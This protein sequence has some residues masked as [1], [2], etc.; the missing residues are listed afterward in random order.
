MPLLSA[1]NVVRLWNFGRRFFSSSRFSPQFRLNWDQHDV[2]GDLVAFDWGVLNLTAPRR[3]YHKRSMTASVML[4][5]GYEDA[6]VDGIQGLP[7]LLLQTRR[8]LLFWHWW[9]V[10]LPCQNDA[11]SHRP[12]RFIRF[13]NRVLPPQPVYHFHRRATLLFHQDSI[14]YSPDWTVEEI[15]HQHFLAYAVLNFWHIKVRD[16]PGWPIHL[17]WLCH[18]G[19]TTPTDAMDSLLDRMTLEFETRMKN[20]KRAGK[21]EKNHPGDWH[22][23]EL[24]E[25]RDELLLFLLTI[26]RVLLW[27]NRLGVW[28]A[29]SENYNLQMMHL[30]LDAFDSFPIADRRA[31]FDKFRANLFSSRR[32]S[33]RCPSGEQSGIT[34]L[35]TPIGPARLRLIP[36]EEDPRV[37]RD[38][39]TVFSSEEVAVSSG[40]LLQGVEHA[41][42]GYVIEGEELD[43]LLRDEGLEPG[44][45]L[46]APLPLPPT[47]SPSP[48]PRDLTPPPITVLEEDFVPLPPS[49]PPEE[50]PWFHQIPSHGSGN[51]TQRAPKSALARKPPPNHERTRR[52]GQTAAV[53]LPRSK[54]L[55][56]L[57]LAFRNETPRDLPSISHQ[58]LSELRGQC[59]IDFVSSWLSGSTTERPSPG[60]DLNSGNIGAK[61][62]TTSFWELLVGFRPLQSNSNATSRR[63]SKQRPKPKPIV[64][65]SDSEDD[66][67]LGKRRKTA[68]QSYVHVTSDEE[69]IAGSVSAVEDMG[70]YKLEDEDFRM[71][72]AE[73]PI[74]DDPANNDPELEP[75]PTKTPQ[76]QQASSS[77]VTLDNPPPGSASS[78]FLGFRLRP[79]DPT[80]S[81][82]TWDEYVEEIVDRV[83]SG[84]EDPHRTEAQLLFMS[85]VFGRVGNELGRRRRNGDTK[86]K[87]EIDKKTDEM[88]GMG[89]NPP[90]VL[91]L[92]PY[93][94][95]DSFQPGSSTCAEFFAIRQGSVVNGF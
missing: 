42:P 57:V 75:A 34:S 68:S 37:Q 81:T 10:D 7:G 77:Q 58:S 1:L 66:V 72:D 59:G 17:C 21:A 18:A 32:P 12:S 36:K 26:E 48:P 87:G 78:H 6:S 73:V 40:L 90:G 14:Q 39:A 62:H 63:R 23:R 91:R 28:V 82:D 22:K 69:E 92:P 35:D 49:T 65:S 13:L 9:F 61:G 4:C 8:D 19:S 88:M 67:P 25:A 71:T 15:A 51:P 44:V 16:P 85:M 38:S 56:L 89:I 53:I 64:I 79:V 43:A 2:W 47:P 74:A 27:L 86:G 24:A 11:R 55:R 41:T 70:N 54:F 29:W 46:G 30:Y 52:V 3:F 50:Q 76:G 31:E 33:S 45:F 83:L 94:R 95:P 20:W 80:S 84:S 5:I 60:S 93:V